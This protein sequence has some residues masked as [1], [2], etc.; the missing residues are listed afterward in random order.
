MNNAFLDVCACDGASQGPCEAGGKLFECSMGD[1]E[2]FGTGYGADTEPEGHA[3]TSW[4]VTEA[5]VT[6]NDTV[7][8]RFAIYD[9][10]NGDFDSLTLVDN[11]RWLAQSAFGTSRVPK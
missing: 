11:V 3:A 10:K 6:P 4:L 2:L 1:A 8:I 5:P 7:S 9:S